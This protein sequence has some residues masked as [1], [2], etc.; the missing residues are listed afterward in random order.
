MLGVALDGDGDG[1]FGGYRLDGNGNVGHSSAV[2]QRNR[3]VAHCVLV[4][5]LDGNV[6]QGQGAGGAVRPGG[7]QLDAVQVQLL[8][9]VI[10]GLVAAADRQLVADGVRGAAADLLA[11]FVRMLELNFP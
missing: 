9:K 7:R 8:T 6:A 10:L 4:I 11:E 3:L 5:A 2:A 1:N